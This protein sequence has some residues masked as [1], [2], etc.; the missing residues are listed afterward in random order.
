[1]SDIVEVESKPE[2]DSLRALSPGAFLRGEL[3]IK[4]VIA[5]G[6]TNLYLADAGGYGVADLKLIAERAIPV[7]EALQVLAADETPQEASQ[8]LA[9]EETLQDA[10]QV[11]APN[12]TDE[13]PVSSVGLTDD[14]EF[15]NSSESGA[16]NSEANIFDALI[17][18]T[19]NS[20]EVEASEEIEPI[21]IV[22]EELAATEEII[23]APPALFVA[24][25]TWEQDE[26]EYCAWEWQETT[27]LQD[28]RET[29]NDERY[30][31]VLA[32]LAQGLEWAHHHALRLEINRD[33][34]RLD[35]DGELRFFGFAAPFSTQKASAL[36]QL[37]G[38]NEFLLKHVFANSGT[39]RLDDQFAGLALT[40]ESKTF[41]HQLNNGEF[42]TFDAA[43]RA[44]HALELKRPIRVRA[45][46]LS[47]VGMQRELNEDSGLIARSARTGHLA[48]QDWELYVVADGMGGHEGGEIASD[49]T[50]RAL[51]E[52]IGNENDWDW[53][54]NLAVK[55]TLVRL[56]DETNRRVAALA[57]DPKYRGSRSRPG[58]T[59]V[60]GLRHNRRVWVGNVGDSRAYLWR[61]EQLIRV[62]KDH[63]YV[64][65]LL[66]AG[67]ISEEEAWDHPEGSI[68][69]AHIG[70]AKL[71]TRDVFARLMLPGDKLLLVS[72]GVVDMLRD[73]EI[74]PF[75]HQAQP[76]EICRAL[77]DAS[78]ESGGADNIT[79]VCVSFD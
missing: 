14:T 32:Q 43:C 3:E 53:N 28:Y 16:M 37:S 45:A 25:E 66:D 74:V 57:E 18:E 26:R 56:I 65:T 9:A 69:T 20:D 64:Q 68:I 6:H 60:F 58:S 73:N 2:P 76:D 17:V 21:E 52:L 63:S 44:L 10:P 62:T 24:G 5:R 31:Q 71:R 12:E 51:H 40:Q 78:N 67:A 19:E 49:L 23:V 42:E 70:E 54:D 29:T 13:E 75:L 35:E 46:L 8:V 15:E 61:D 1:M 41:A 79:V 11:L 34:L 55:N 39:M 22:R 30:L 7:E 47:D 48:Q 36:E 4:E 50:V 38:V 27:A 72:D 59:L 77:V 33:T